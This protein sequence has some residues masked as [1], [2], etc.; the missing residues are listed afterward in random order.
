MAKSDLWIQDG[1]LT[2]FIFVVIIVL[3]ILTDSVTHLRQRFVVLFSRKI[4]DFV[5]NFGSICIFFRFYEWLMVDFYEVYEQ[6]T[7]GVKEA[8]FAGIFLQEMI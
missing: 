2:P 4:V 7:S 6:L 1:Y 8:L 3:L 5:V